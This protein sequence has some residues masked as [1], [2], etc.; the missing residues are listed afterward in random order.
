MFPKLSFHEM[1]EVPTNILCQ[2]YHHAQLACVHAASVGDFET[3]HEL[4][5][6][7]V[8]ARYVVMS[9]F[10]EPDYG[11]KRFYEAVVYERN[12]LAKY[13][14]CPDNKPFRFTC[15]AL[16]GNAMDAGIRVFPHLYPEGWSY[17]QYLSAK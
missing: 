15:G 12:N 7:V 17:Y 11:H 5:S 3:A 1:K 13:I 2:I 9:R 14:Q 6:T 8:D 10:E 4:L 16:V